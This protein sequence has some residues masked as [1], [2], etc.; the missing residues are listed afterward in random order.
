MALIVSMLFIT[1][2]SLVEIQNYLAGILFVSPTVTILI[3]NRRNLKLH[4]FNFQRWVTDLLQ[5]R[6][7]ILAI[8]VPSLLTLIFSIGVL[9]SNG[10]QGWDSNAYHLSISGLLLNEGSSF[11][12]YIGQG[13]YTIL[14]PYGAHSLGALST[15]ILGTSIFSALWTWITVFAFICFSYGTILD[16]KLNWERNKFLLYLP[17]VIWLVPSVIGQTTHFYVDAI[18]GVFVAA[19]LVQLTSIVK[20]TKASKLNWILIGGMGSAAI[21]V[22]SQ[23]LY[24]VA[25]VMTL[26]LMKSIRDRKYHEY[27][28]TVIPFLFLGLIPYLRNYIIFENPIYPI[29]FIN[30]PGKK[31]ISALSDAVESFAPQAWG[32]NL[33]IRIIY[34]LTI[35]PLIVMVRVVG[36]QIGWYDATRSDLSG[37]SYDTVTGG[38]GT[39]AALVLCV[40]IIYSL[41][42]LTSRF[43]A[44]N[45]LQISWKRN[46][47]VPIVL[48]VAVAMFLTPGSWWVR[49]NMGQVLFII[50]LAFLYLTKKSMVPKIQY[51]IAMILLPAIFAQAVVLGSFSLKYERSASRA[52]E[53]VFE[54]AF[55]LSQNT[56]LGEV[57][58]NK[59]IFVEPRPTFTS[60][61]WS[62]NC[63][64]YDW[65]NYPNNYFFSAGDYVVMTTDLFSRFAKEYPGKFENTRINAWFDPEGKYGSVLVKILTT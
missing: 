35:S 5:S 25:L 56:V 58:C 51:Y 3:K 32:D 50:F 53:I 21:S 61:F 10:D 40:M 42:S 28:L 59:L 49:Y 30:F 45:V 31:S 27:I 41:V 36:S 7:H 8:G 48:V 1:S 19:L 9:F 12:P 17:S 11:S 2:N 14:T 62:L 18:M 6:H 15:F 37:F 54:P 23:A 65:T 60:T 4:S 34:S 39:P 57:S 44:K 22:K 52:S 55:G 33:I 38:V 29:Q 24:P 47:L 43:R 26:L 16:S 63:K 13:T 20:V 64:N 46:Y